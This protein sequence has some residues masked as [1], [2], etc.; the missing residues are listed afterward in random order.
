MV[1]LFTRI[2]H[3]LSWIFKGEKIIKFQR[4]SSKNSFFFLFFFFLNNVLINQII[5]KKRGSLSQQI[6]IQKFE[7][8]SSNGY[9]EIYLN[10]TFNLFLF[11]FNVV[12]IINHLYSLKRVVENISEN[13]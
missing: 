11:P 9:Y 1:Q 13:C 3:M 4:K 2:S 12:L 7:P 5:F 10:F 6:L 8:I